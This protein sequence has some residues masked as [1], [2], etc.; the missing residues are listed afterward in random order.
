M[1]KYRTRWTITHP[2]TPGSIPELIEILLANRGLEALGLEAR[3]EELESDA[4][5][6][7]NLESAAQLVAQHVDRGSKIVLAGDYDCD[8]LTSIAQLALFLRRLGHRE[9]VAATP[10]NRSQG[11]GMPL[12]AVRANQDA[13]LFL[14]LDCGT[15]DE[16][17]VAAA[18]EAGADVVVID[19]HAIDAASRV[20]PATFLVNPHHPDCPSTFKAFATA[21]LVLLFL[22]RLRQALAAGREPI[23][24][25][26]DYLALAAVGTVADM[27]PL[28]K[29]NRAIVR[30]GLDHLTRGC[31]APLQQLR[32]VA[33]LAGR[34]L[35]TGHIGF[36]IAPRL[37]AAARVG[38]ARTALDLLLAEDP[39]RI[40]ALA[41][42]LDELN[43]RR[44]K[45]VESIG[46]ALLA[47]VAAMPEART[48][49]LAD[50]GFPQ[51]INGILA[52]RI[53]REFGRPAIVMQ[54]IAKEGVATGSGRSVPGFDLHQALSESRDLLERWG[55]HAMAAGLSVRI[56]KLE[57]FRER[58]ES[59]TARLHPEPLVASEP[60]DMEI[61]P[62][63]ATPALIEAL[64][65]LEPYGVG[66][67]SPRFAMRGEE[68]RTLRRFGRRGGGGPH[69]ELS[70]ASGL[71][72]VYWNGAQGFTGRIGERV[73]LV[74]S[75]N[76]NDYRGTLQAVVRDLG[77][78]LFAP[79]RAAAVTGEGCA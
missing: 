15:F 76:W 32:A 47:R 74:C 46:G 11:Y 60:V 33:G 5:Q 54:V 77:A 44:Q 68:I 37:N 24:I 73:D 78:D 65:G 75:L 23:A 4:Q 6:I 72:A 63:L 71:S 67:P 35:N 38:D 19:H 52:Q 59:I 61:D 50:P 18:R 55:G 21:G 53:V 14:A 36:Q 7:R 39:A 2:H 9:I 8:G 79:V 29:G 25:N 64:R 56:E 41:L 27:M 69:L 66:N 43:R 16:V 40:E 22:S 49:V 31:F 3:L 26:G 42:Q 48:V 17:P 62:A 30:H 13:G 12:E 1:E 57:A 58:F 45:Q 10:A 20:A 34:P 70:F 51:G 28:R